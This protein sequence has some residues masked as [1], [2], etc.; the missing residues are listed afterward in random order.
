MIDTGSGVLA[1]EFVNERIGDFVRSYF[2]DYGLGHMPLSDAHYTVE[3]RVL[4]NR[5]NRI[6]PENKPS[7]TTRSFKFHR[8]SETID[9]ITQ[10][11]DTSGGVTMNIVVNRALKRVT[12]ELPDDDVGSQVTAMRLVRDSCKALILSAGYVG[13]HA[14]TLVGKNG[15][16]CLLGPKYAGKTTALLIG[17][18]STSS[19]IMAND[20]TF[21]K[22][23]SGEYLARALP[24]ALGIRVPTLESLGAPGEA[25]AHE[26]ERHVDHLTGELRSYISPQKCANALG[27]K[28]QH[29]SKVSFLVAIDPEN[30]ASSPISPMPL[31]E[32]EIFMRQQL[33]VAPPPQVLAYWNS[34]GYKGLM[35]S[36]QMSRS[37][38]PAKARMP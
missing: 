4:N 21:L 23:S 16:V 35:P 6:W 12:V 15:A 1:V 19:A 30:V 2:C 24:V 32:A 5:A 33:A 7:L 38:Q 10:G 3:M 11:G 20:E 26:S 22:N 25:I 31:D 8:V 37:A 9:Q 34:L 18:A 17:A 27:C 14:S 28:L 13:F 29:T 36:S